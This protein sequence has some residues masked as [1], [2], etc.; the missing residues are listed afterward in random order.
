MTL[1][2]NSKPFWKKARG[3]HMLTAAIVTSLGLTI[4]FSQTIFTGKEGI[5]ALAWFL[6]SS[7]AGVI[8]PAFNVPNEWIDFENKI[9]PHTFW[10][11]LLS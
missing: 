6:V 7:I 11:E 3:D 5:L 2:K 4:I 10:K 1:S 8:V 9:P